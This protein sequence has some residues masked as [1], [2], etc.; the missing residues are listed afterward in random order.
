VARQRSGW[1]SRR[2]CA[3][4]P[5]RR[6]RRSPKYVGT[7]PDG[8]NRYQVRDGLNHFIGNSAYQVVNVSNPMT[9][10]QVNTLWANIKN[11]VNQSYTV[12][13]NIVTHAGGLRPP[14]YAA[15]TNVD[16][17]IVVW[18]YRTNS[19]GQN[20]VLI[21]DPASGRAG[22]NPNHAYWMSLW[23]LK[24]VITKTYVG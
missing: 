19:S 16:H 13:V 4:P 15:S 5:R 21:G 14:G 1:G 23:L 11:N 12:P 18:G 24:S 20:E 8:T 17:W 3:R 2:P 22:F 6:R 10:A 7:T 9:N